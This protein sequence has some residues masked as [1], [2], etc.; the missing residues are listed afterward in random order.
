MTA[1]EATPAAQVIGVLIAAGLYAAAYLSFVHLLR[2]PRN[3]LPFSL[4]ES[5]GTAA[6]AVLTLAQVSLSADGLD[7]PALAITAGFVVVV[8]TIIAAPALTFR[9]ASP[10]IEFLA[11]HA[12]H[13]GLWL[14]APALV[15]G[16]AS[17]NIKLQAVLATAMAIELAWC[18]TC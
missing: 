12:D 5:L 11:K 1:I 4:P 9:P 6:L 13:A 8:F 10:P 2:Y 15:A 18:L 3:W 7:G 17:P 16:L 14:L